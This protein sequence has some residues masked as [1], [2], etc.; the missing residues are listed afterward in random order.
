M[1]PSLNLP[2]PL[3]P[4]Q[5]AGVSFLKERNS[6]LLA[7]EMGL[8]KTVQTAVALTLAMVDGG[9]RAL[10]I[11]PA[12]LKLNWA[13]ELS[14]WASQLV[15]RQVVGDQQDRLAQ[16]RL[17]I[18]V[19][20][21]SYEQVR[22]DYQLIFSESIHFD[23][24]VLDEAQRIKNPDS[25][26]S[27]ACRVVPRSRSWAL[28]GTPV[29]NRPNDLVAVSRF[30]EP[31]LLSKGMSREE[32][33]RRIAPIFLRRRKSEVGSELPPIVV[34]DLRLELTG[35]QR[36]AYDA[37]WEERRSFV[38][39]GGSGQMLALLTRLKQIC[40]YEPATAE[41]SKLEALSTIADGVTGP[42]G[43]LLVFSQYVATL[44]W[45]SERLALPNSVYHGG[46]DLDR[47]DSMLRDFRS[48][49][50][51]RALLLSITAGG[52]GLN[53]PEASTVVLYDRWWNPAV[54]DQ[55]I[56]RADRIGRVHSL[57]AYRF[58]VVD[59]VEERID[60][61][62]Q[63][64]RSIFEEYVEQAPQAMPDAASVGDL[65]RVL[66]LADEGGTLA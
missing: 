57:L 23:F 13:L 33:H 17:P 30:V 29:E 48:R 34:Q 54:E 52:V 16:Y 5:W 44:K 15:V 55:A 27:F 65:R 8:G 22:T 19:L 1:Q 26:T 7:D 51:P 40:N 2:A 20:I 21:A 43:K 14:R 3:R 59:S 41:S 39:E 4:Y 50:G 10:L 42:E 66:G 49:P 25:E 11:V 6:A 45:L 56:Q 46:L 60:E 24:V 37:L 58:L 62:L 18:Q 53:I 36:A 64:K 35:G 12:S 28:T 61:I 9:G 32:I 31:G 63:E 47:R 38:G